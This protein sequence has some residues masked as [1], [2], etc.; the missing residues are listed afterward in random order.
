MI[1][2]DLSV[3]NMAFE[4]GLDTCKTKQ[5]G[6]WLWNPLFLA[7]RD[8]TAWIRRWNQIKSRD[9]FSAAAAAGGLTRRVAETD[10]AAIIDDFQK[11]KIVCRVLG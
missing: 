11:A 6:W 2:D 4:T 9:G 10:D 3:R 5:L 8:F 1:W 7:A